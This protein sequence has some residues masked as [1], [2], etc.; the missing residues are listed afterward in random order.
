MEGDVPARPGEVA[1]LPAVS[2][3][4]QML[5]EPL[6][7]NIHVTACMEM[8]QTGY[9]QAVAAAAGCAVAKPIPD[10][11][12]ID[13]QVSHGSNKHTMDSIA[14]IRVQLKATSTVTR[15]TIRTKGDF[16]LELENAD[17]AR[18][19]ISP[20]TIPRLLVVLL[21][22]KDQAEWLRA[23]HDEL[24]V[25]H[26]AYWINLE[27]VSTRGEKTTTVRVALDHVFDDRALCEIM[28]KVGAGETPR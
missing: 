27:G 13:Y 17:L 14:E 11:H 7:G 3:S 8:L 28:R 5:V 10:A 18:L 26:C 4:S 15:E 2:T 1:A 22:P 24:A 19:S 16:P 9:L 12:G 23:D 25:R 20:V 6:R 21:L